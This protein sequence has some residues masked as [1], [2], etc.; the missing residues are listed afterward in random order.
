MLCYIM[1]TEWKFPI[2]NL[3]FIIQRSVLEIW[4]FT[5]Q[6][7]KLCYHLWQRISIH[8]IAKH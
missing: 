3:D 4:T 6:E 2:I 5:S 1:A 8:L 7:A